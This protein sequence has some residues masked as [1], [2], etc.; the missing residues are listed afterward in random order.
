MG[1]LDRRHTVHNER[2]TTEAGAAIQLCSTL[3]LAW[4]CRDSRGFFLYIFPQQRGGNVPAPFSVVTHPSSRCSRR[5]PQS[6]CRQTGRCS[7]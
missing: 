5:P 1:A 3:Q 4:P 7:S 6:P 2:F